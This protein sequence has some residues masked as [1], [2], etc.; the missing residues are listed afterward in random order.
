MAWEDGTFNRE[1]I[2]HPELGKPGPYGFTLFSSGPKDARSDF[3][4]KIVDGKTIMFFCQPY[5]I[6]GKHGA[7]CNHVAHTSSGATFFYFFDLSGLRDALEVEKSL[8]QL[9]DGFSIKDNK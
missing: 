8:K 1:E 5:D 7:I 3:Y 4:R 2:E 9:V 6:D